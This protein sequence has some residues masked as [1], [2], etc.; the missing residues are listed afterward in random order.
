MYGTA[1]DGDLFECMAIDLAIE[2]GILPNAVRKR[3]FW[4]LCH[5]AMANE[6]GVGSWDSHV[7]QVIRGW[8]NH[9]AFRVEDVDDFNT[10][11]H[12]LID[13][14]EGNCD[15]S[16]PH[17]LKLHET[18]PISRCEALKDFV[19][20]RV[21]LARYWAKSRRIYGSAILQLRFQKLQ[22]HESKRES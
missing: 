18:I 5:N 7:L 20:K 2:L 9:L 13:W 10:S 8:L 3:C 14:I 21:G 22:M 12:E 17:K 11:Y 19:Q 16:L 4:H 1:V 15:A 6:F